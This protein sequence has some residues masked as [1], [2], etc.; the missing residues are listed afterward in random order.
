MPVYNAEKFLREAI[1]SVLNQSYGDFEF[2]ILNDGSKDSSLEIINSYTDP[3]I[4]LIHNP[5]NLGYCTK[6]N[7]GLKAASGKYIA[8]MDNDDVSM[9]ERFEKEVTFLDKNPE[10]GLC[11]C[12]AMVIDEYGN[13]INPQMFPIDIAPLEWQMIWTNP[14][15]HP[16]VMYRKALVDK[17]QWNYEQEMYPADDYSLWCKM[18][19]STRLHRLS[20]V[21]FKYRILNGSAYHSNFQKAIDKSIQVGESYLRTYTLKENVP[22]F[23]LEI[24]KFSFSGKASFDNFDLLEIKL[25]TSQLVELVNS[26][27]NLSNAELKAVKVNNYQRYISFI[28]RLNV[29]LLKK[30][31][32]FLKNI[33]FAILFKT[34]IVRVG[35]RK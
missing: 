35:F 28:K 17:Y 23:H 8:R 30:I 15:A 20:E 25:W 3:R 32:L 11:C 9:P 18:A 27:F 13:V 19:E 31:S 4:K 10:F 6:L 22:W 29:P 12:N 1:D 26:K 16:T 24:M 34:L 5:I 14:I 33:P 2:I 21:L 7:E